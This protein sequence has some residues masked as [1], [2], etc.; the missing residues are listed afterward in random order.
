MNFKNINLELSSGELAMAYKRL[1]KVFLEV[2]FAIRQ[3]AFELSDRAH[4]ERAVGRAH[5][6]LTL[7]NRERWE[8]AI[9]RAYSTIRGYD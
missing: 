3:L 7:N 5:R 4:W 9:N 8:R 2:T 1:R 6:Q